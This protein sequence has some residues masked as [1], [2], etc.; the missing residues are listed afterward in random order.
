MDFIDP[1]PG[2]WWRLRD[3]VERQKVISSDYVDSDVLALARSGA[4]S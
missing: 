2:G 3:I 1:W 4:M